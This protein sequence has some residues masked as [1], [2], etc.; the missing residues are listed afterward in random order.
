MVRSGDALP[1]A[2][3]AAAEVA[4]RWFGVD[5]GSVQP[6]ARDASHD[7]YRVHG[8]SGEHYLR[9]YRDADRYG[10][11]R[12][13]RLIRHVSLAGVPAPR[14]VAVAD[15]ATLVEA[16][17]S[18]WAMFPAADGTQLPFADL[19]PAHTASA[20][21]MLARLHQAAA[22]MPEAGF[23]SWPLRWDGPQQ[24]TRLQHVLR[25]IDTTGIDPDTDTWARRRVQAQLDWLDDPTCPH[26]YSPAFPAQVIHGD[27][28]NAAL[29]FAG[30]QVS[31]VIDWDGARVMPRA[32]ELTRACSLLCRMQPELTFAFLDGYATV[33]RL[34]RGELEDGARAWGCFADHDASAIEQAYLQGDHDAARD[35]EHRPFAPF[36]DQWRALGF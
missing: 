30:S 20:G 1:A 5:T 35:I 26:S 11:D 9:R 19:T 22:D 8:A 23:S 13:H 12:E 24:Q 31:G 28:R 34:D 36:R 25:A 29:F 4:T 17:G 10:V 6:V 32:F 16:A 2:D 3:A 18:V 15:G 21:A 14:A 33:A 27:Y 7:I